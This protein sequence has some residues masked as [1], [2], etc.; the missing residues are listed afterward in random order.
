MMDDFSIDRTT[1]PPAPPTAAPSPTTPV[2]ASAILP[3]VPPLRRADSPATYLADPVSCAIS[4]RS[5]VMWTQSPYRIGTLHRGTPDR[6]DASVLAALTPIFAHS[7]LAPRYDIL[8]DAADLEAIDDATF[9][10]V[11]TFL[12]EWVDYLAG[13]VRRIAIVAPTGLAGAAFRGLFHHWIAPR[14]DARLCATR[15]DAYTM[16]E[17][18]ATDALQI[19]TLRD[20]LAGPST[21][22]RV[23]EMIL[24]QLST[25]ILPQIAEQLGLGIRTLQRQLA[26][27]GT[28]FRDEVLHVRIATAK[29]RLLACD[30]KVEQVARSVGFTSP[31]A[32]TASFHKVVGLAP[33]VFRARHAAALG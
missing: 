14:F 17:M 9:T 11:E 28:S 27:L 31:A 20:E 8:H 23:R 16:L 1:P 19:D 6:L 33:T 21:L 25:P 24:R 29:Q 13:R 26:S 30:D 15:A 2:Q 7:S 4:G 18:S 32:F 22:R 3:A 10:A 12:R 5:F